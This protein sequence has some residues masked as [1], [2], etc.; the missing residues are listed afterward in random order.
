MALDPFSILRY[1]IGFIMVFGTVVALILGLTGIAPDAVYL[2]GGIWG[3][4]GAV[5]L[6][7]DYFLEPGTETVA[8]LISNAGT[9]RVASQHGEIETL[10]VQGRYQEA[11]ER[12]FRVAVD[13][14]TPA[15]A[16]LRR[17]ELLAGPLAEPGTAAAELTNYRDA[18]RRPLKAAE[19]VAIGLALVDLYETKLQEPARAMFELRRLLDRYPSSGQVRRIRATLN[20]LKEHHFGDAF[21]PTSAP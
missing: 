19:D 10:A 16:M 9:Q 2:A 3:L 4:Y 6:G 13:G 17:A 7:M 11:A 18:P 1:A 8:R 21:A 12:W 14:D 20:D 15:L 5:R